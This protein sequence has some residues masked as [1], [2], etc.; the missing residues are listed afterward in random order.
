[1]VV[2]KD[3]WYTSKYHIHSVIWYVCQISK[4]GQ[5]DGAFL[6]YMLALVDANIINELGAVVEK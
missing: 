3:I 6:S 1:M 4:F 5:P 2:A